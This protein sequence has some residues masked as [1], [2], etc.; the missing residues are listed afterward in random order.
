MSNSLKKLE[1]E[2]EKMLPPELENRITSH[3]GS[4]NHWGDMAE[5]FVSGTVSTVAMLFG[6]D[7]VPTAGSGDSW[8][9]KPETRD[10]VTSDDI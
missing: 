8:R 7:R 6:S 10:N 4:I 5:L 1:E 9:E 3:I 2:R